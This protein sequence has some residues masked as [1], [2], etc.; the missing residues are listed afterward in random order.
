MTSESAAYLERLDYLRDEFKKEIRNMG[1]EE[2]AWKPLG[3]DTNSPYVLATHVA[4]TEAFHIHQ[5][6]GG[7]DVNRNREAEFAASGMD[8]SHLEQMLI[9]TGDTTHQVLSKATTA[10]L[11]ETF[12]YR[13][14]SVTRRWAVLHTLEH[15]GQHLGH[16]TLT[17]QLYRAQN[18]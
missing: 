17:R 11:D 15:I 18:G 6:V 13:G 12:D 10:D 8:P 7:I 9:E 16:L 14:Q 2:L 5:L 4:G 1:P 3:E